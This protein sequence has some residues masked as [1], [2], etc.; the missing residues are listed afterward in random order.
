MDEQTK[1]GTGAAAGIALLALI[2][3]HFFESHAVLVALLYA[4][5]IGV[6]VWGL[7][8]ACLRAIRKNLMKGFGR[9][10]PQYLMVF[11]ACVF[12][13]GLVAFLQMNVQQEEHHP[14]Q[15]AASS[16]TPTVKPEIVF[17]F[18]NDA[19]VE[20]R[21]V[22]WADG[23]N[24]GLFESRYYLM[25]GNALD[26]G[27]AVK[28]IK[29][30]VFF[31]GQEPLLA[32]VKESGDT[33]TDI[34]HGEWAFFEIGKIVAVDGFPTGGFVTFNDDEK[35]QYSYL[36]SDH[37]RHFEVSTATGVK[38]Y[39]IYH[40]PDAPDPDWPMSVVV[41]ADDAISLQLRVKLDLGGKTPV[42]FE[43]TR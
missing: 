36:K 35:K 4:V 8:P 32:R 28:N 38:A 37:P 2:E 43:E 18:R 14:V 24:A 1:I 3:P 10:W 42:R 22:K 5:L 26:T 34:R 39:G 16:E 13:V 7:A 21:L 23:T 33:S 40:N 9:M 25:V 41:T 30:R 6:M 20:T 17:K 29:T 15:N 12:F 31:L 11:S 19:F 27:K